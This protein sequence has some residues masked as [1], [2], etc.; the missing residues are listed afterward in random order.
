MRMASSFFFPEAAFLGK[1]KESLLLE[2]ETR[3]RLAQL[4]LGDIFTTGL[5]QE[6]VGRYYYSPS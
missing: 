3:R 5:P 6:E 2:A 4:S 1:T